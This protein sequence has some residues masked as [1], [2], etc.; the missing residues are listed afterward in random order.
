MDEKKILTLSEVSKFYT[1]TQ[2]V[3]VGLHRISLS[4]SIGEFVAVTGESGSGKST[5]A[6]V[7][8]G[9]LPYES[10]EMFFDGK[11]TSCFGGADR[12]KY[13]AESVSFISQNYG[14]LPGASVLDNIL[15]AL[16]IAGLPKKEA[17]ARAQEI[18]EEVELSSLASRRAAYLSSGQKQRLSIARALAKPARILIADEPTGNLDPENSEKVIRLLTKAAGE[19]LVLLITHEFSEAEPYVTRHIVLEDG[20]VAADARLRPSYLLPEKSDTQSAKAD[21]DESS[22]KTSA[23]REKAKKRRTAAALPVKIASLTL[24]SRPVLSVVLFLLFALEAFGIFAFLGTLIPALDD[25]STRIYNNTIFQNGAPERLVV[26]RKDGTPLTDED[27]DAI[28]ALAHVARVERYGYAADVHYAYRKDVDYRSTYRYGFGSSEL[29]IGEYI[30]LEA[31]TPFLQTVPHLKQN[32]A[33]LSEGRLPEDFYEAV[34][35]RGAANLGEE[36]RI[37]LTDEKNYSRAQYI[38]LVVK[39]VG[40]T[41]VGEGLWLSDGVGALAESM[42]KKSPFLWIPSKDKGLADSFVILSKERDAEQVKIPAT[43]ETKE[44]ELKVVSHNSS[45]QATLLEV[46]EALYQK[47]ANTAPLDQLSVTMEDYA[48]TDRVIDALTARGYL[49]LSARRVGADRID[50]DASEER[51]LT[52]GICLSALILTS[53]LQIFLLS[54]LFSSQND[55]YRLL[56]DIGLREKTAS[57]SV[58]FELF[59]LSILGHI[60]TFSVVL[61]LSCA[62][63]DRLLAITR[64]LTFGRWMLLFGIGLLLTCLS[65]RRILKRLKKQVYPNTAKENDLPRYTDEEVTA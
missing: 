12:E 51:Y 33:F 59:S 41:D 28:A 46:S 54:A 32:E 42:T 56:S 44:F 36:V 39:I 47:M 62:G 11:P 24:R 30:T 20:R 19:R 25:T 45:M 34:A 22:E 14:I 2:T 63:V 65:A 53:L 26:I 64:Y 49:A 27:A 61:I 23:K 50:G 15:G 5:L 10:G 17:E 35:T 40:I 29:A 60:F 37:F 3:V 55:T 8:G 6:H 16:A 52:I 31:G 21:P 9:I 48:Y 18:L 1:G 57:A 7:L 43:E 58:L 38:E 4:F 13:R